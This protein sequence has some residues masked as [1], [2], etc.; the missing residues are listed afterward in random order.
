MHTAIYSEATG[1]LLA[2]DPWGGWCGVVVKLAASWG[3]GY[4]GCV[5]VCVW[6][7]GKGQGKGK[8]RPIDYPHVDSH[9]FLSGLN[10]PYFFQ[11]ALGLM[12]NLFLLSRPSF[13]T[14]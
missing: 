4:E 3:L 5:C 13:L 1:G 10:L 14:L 12:E 6:W 9:L 2:M 8:H 7:E 11:G